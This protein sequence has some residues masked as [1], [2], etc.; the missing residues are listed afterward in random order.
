MGT[1]I[2]VDRDIYTSLSSFLVQLFSW[3]DWQ[4]VGLVLCEYLKAFLE[5][6]RL[7]SDIVMSGEGILV[8]DH[9][10]AW[11]AH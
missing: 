2:E 10:H 4:E 1:V 11:D 5:V 7:Q 3:K 6:Q 9:Q 8:R